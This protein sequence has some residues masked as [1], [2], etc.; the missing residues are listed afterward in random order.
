MVT[1]QG[2][3]DTRQKLTEQSQVTTFLKVIPYCWPYL[4]GLMKFAGGLGFLSAKSWLTVRSQWNTPDKE[5]CNGN[6]DTGQTWARANYHCVSDFVLKYFKT[7]LFGLLGD[8]RPPL[9]GSFSVDLFYEQQSCHCPWL[10]SFIC[11]PSRKRWSPALIL[12]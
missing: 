2:F 5:R 7:H 1:T 4:P 3:I 12:E 9:Q 8:I 10:F 6:C 11:G